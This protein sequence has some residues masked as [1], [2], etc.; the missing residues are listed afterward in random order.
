VTERPNIVVVHD[1]SQDYVRLALE[2]ARRSGNR[3][4]QLSFADKSA[5]QIDFEQRWRQMS[6][7]DRRF[8][9]LCM[10]RYFVIQKAMHDQGL[11]YVFDLDSDV[12]AFDDMDVFRARHLDGVFCGLHMPQSQPG[13]RYSFGAHTSYWTR[14]AIDD[15]CVFL[16]NFYE[17]VPQAAQ[18]KWDWH[19]STGAPGGVCDMT[20][21][22]LWA[23]DRGDVMNFAK[24]IGEAVFDY[25]LN[26][27]ENYAKG[28][29][30]T[31]FG[32]KIIAFRDGQ[33]YG[34]A[35]NGDWIRFR[36]LHFQG[37]I[38]N[39]MRRF[40]DAKGYAHGPL[41]KDWLKLKLKALAGNRT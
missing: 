30:R 18:E 35:A 32:K 13:L 26:T 29:Y 28:E 5:S 16:L 6:N 41:L 23:K 25:N 11:D 31:R 27:S 17:E 12:L 37:S 7:Y 2:T 15:F 9:L 1:G 40:A 22:Y 3:P 24:P 21:L 33:P 8:D 38:K 4:S 14:D 39:Q 36:S 34:R 20:L 19:R 10:T